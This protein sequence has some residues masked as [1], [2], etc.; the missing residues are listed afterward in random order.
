MNTSTMP[1]ISKPG[2]QMQTPELVEQILS[3][4]RNG[5]GQKRIAKELGISRNTVRRYLR[6]NGWKPYRAPYKEKKLANLEGWLKETFLQH[7]GNSAVV[8]Q[9]LKRQYG[10]NLHSSTVRRAVQRYRRELEAEAK[11]TVRFETPPG[12]QLQIDFGSMTIQIGGVAQR[13]HFFAAVLGYSRRQYVQAFLHER[14]TAWLQGIEGAFHHFNGI[15]DE[16]LMDNAKSLVAKHN[17]Q[18]REVIFNDRFH[19]FARY[20]DFTPK[21]CAPYR[22]RTKGKDENTVKYLKKNAIAGREFANF[23]ELEKHLN[24]WMREISDT[25]IHG[26]T[27]EKPIDRFEVAERQALKPLNAKPPFHQ[28]REV[29]RVVQTD[30]CIELDS[31]FYSVPWSLIKESVTVQVI[32]QEL[33][34]YYHSEPV[35]KHPVCLGR[36]ERTL[37]KSH[38]NGIISAPKLELVSQEKPAELLRPLADYE[39]VAGGR[40]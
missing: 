31:N 39:A 12:K 28:I 30:A 6:S 7:K 21:A 33:H 19:A 20:W 40:L 5:W 8:H 26:T 37:E 9:E 3:L 27:H 10:L 38:L 4:S 16:I 22:A 32:D 2:G 29:Q 36:R 24:W 14:Q 35:A 17:P 13:V 34:I 25:R 23:E 11:A 15:P 18:T 1:P